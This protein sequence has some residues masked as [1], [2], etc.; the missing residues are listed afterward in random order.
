MGCWSRTRWSPSCTSCTPASPSS[1][2]ARTPVWASGSASG[3]ML[4]RRCCW[5]WGR[6]SGRRS[7]RRSPRPAR[8]CSRTPAS[9]TPPAATPWG[10]TPSWSISTTTTSRAER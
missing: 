2:R 10:T 9:G 5:S 7:S 3:R 8:P 1:G 4:T 6:R